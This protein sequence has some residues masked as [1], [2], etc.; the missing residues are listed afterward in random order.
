MLVQKAEPPGKV[1]EQHEL[2]AQHG[3]EGGMLS[4]L[5]GHG[6]RD[7]EPPE[8]FAARGARARVGQLRILARDQHAVVAAV[9]PRP[10]RG[11]RA[12]VAVPSSWR[13]SQYVT[14]FQLVEWKSD[15]ASGR[16]MSNS[17]T[18]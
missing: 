5:L 2:L 15:V 16:E 12:H 4:Q 9:G 6:D 11:G 3:N 17:V 7:P 14:D 8:V 10:K 1:P 13:W 18:K